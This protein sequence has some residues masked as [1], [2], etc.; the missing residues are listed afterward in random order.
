MILKSKW[1]GVG[2]ETRLETPG[3]FKGKK[4]T[5]CAWWYGS[6]YRRFRSKIAKIKKDRQKAG[7]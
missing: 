3:I 2:I 1:L 7:Q 6:G 5:V 4:L